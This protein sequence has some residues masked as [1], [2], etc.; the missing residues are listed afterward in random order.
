MKI[1]A[2]VSASL[3]LA[4]NTALA[5]EPE[6][7]PVPV[8][9]QTNDL[10]DDDYDGVINARDTCPN[11]PRQAEVTNDG[12]EEYFEATEK[13]Q[14]KVLFANNS[15]DVPPAFMSQ[16]RTMA[17]F[18][19]KYPEASIELQGYASKTGSAEKNLELSKGRAENVRR[20]LI[21]Y[22]VSHTR[23]KT[24]G[25]GDNIDVAGNY[26]E[27]NQALDRKVVATVVGH[28]GDVV[29][30]WSIFTTREK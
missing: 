16:I 29:E 2:I 15:T 30:E 9:V 4:S 14:L 5:E 19:D 20:A 1:W 21:S 27:V 8:A 26:T 23:I 24:V 7:I 18:L 12:C 13:R 11:T 22:G 6:Y 3:V 17:E 10:T 25:F 28:Q